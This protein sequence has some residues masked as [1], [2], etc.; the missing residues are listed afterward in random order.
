M[1]VENGGIKG[2]YRS[3]IENA[4]FIH[5][6][7]AKALNLVVPR[8]DGKSNLF[9]LGYEL[10]SLVSVEHFRD[11]IS[12]VLHVGCDQILWEIQDS[13]AI[14]FKPEGTPSE[15]KF[16]KLHCSV[17]CYFYEL[18]HAYHSSLHKKRP[19]YVSSDLVQTQIVGKSETDLLREVEYDGSTNENLVKNTYE[20]QN[21]QFIPVRKT[22][23][24]LW[25]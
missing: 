9:D 18:G 13:K 16:L 21:L 19:L 15:S 12:Q 11:P 5:L 17:N 4:F 22:F 1:K 14:G 23:L 3:G 7:I 8:K 25:K 20:P 2:D 24:I 10:T 6:D